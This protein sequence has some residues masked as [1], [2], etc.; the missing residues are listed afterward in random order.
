MFVAASSH[1]F[2]EQPF[3]KAC[4]LIADLE[5]DKVEIWLSESGDHLKPSTVA[6]DPE[7]FFGQFREF[8]RLSPAALHLQD[9]VDIPT[10]KGLTKAAKLLRVTQLTVPASP[11]GTPFNMEIDRLRAYVAAASEDGVRVSLKTEIGHLTEDPHTA[12]ELCQSVKG[13]GLTLDP[14]HYI[15]GPN[16]GKSFDQVYPYVFH[17]H[18]RDTTPEELQVPVGLGE[19][20]Y[21]RLRNQLHRE[22]YTRAL[23]IEILP[24]R[25]PMESR[26]LELRTLRRL[27]ESIL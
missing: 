8:T 21:N 6:A 13:L 20:D 22:N 9:D 17:A 4:D 25:T 24:E 26:P 11:L 5:F 15:C 27:L 14:S 10:L 19:V 23:S 1:C 2:A 3:E 12:V 7:R 18:L 16:K